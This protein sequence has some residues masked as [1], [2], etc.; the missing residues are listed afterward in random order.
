MA[1]SKALMGLAL[2]TAMMG[3]AMSVM[4]GKGTHVETVAEA[5]AK[6]KPKE[7]RAPRQYTD[8]QRAARKA[9]KAQIKARRKAKG[10]RKGGR[11]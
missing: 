8:E 10:C 9:H 4:P 3:A 7:Y 1:R 6:A 2:T 11:H 5:E